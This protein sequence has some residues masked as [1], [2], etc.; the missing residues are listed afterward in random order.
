MVKN[1]LLL[2]YSGLRL[3]IQHIILQHL[4][5]PFLMILFCIVTY[6]SPEHSQSILHWTLM[7]SISYTDVSH[8]INATHNFCWK[9]NTT[10]FL[11]ST[12]YFRRTFLNWTLWAVL[13]VLDCKRA[14]AAQT[15]YTTFV[16]ASLKTTSQAKMWPK[17]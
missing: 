2:E 9:N 17:L 13:M 15:F 6:F 3:Y 5:I 16:L 14:E 8:S 10:Q 11:I 4:S 7:F 1:K 12:F